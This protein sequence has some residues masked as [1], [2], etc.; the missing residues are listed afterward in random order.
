MRVLDA[1]RIG[2]PIVL[3][4]FRS[5]EGMKRVTRGP[6]P[7]RPRKRLE[8]LYIQK[9]QQVIVIENLLVASVAV[10]IEPSSTRIGA[11]PRSK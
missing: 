9:I 2:P 3:R 1:C 6:W 4:P 5:R 7:D 11:P 8:I 10:I